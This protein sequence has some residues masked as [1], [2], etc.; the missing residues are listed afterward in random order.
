MARKALIGIVALL[1]V[2]FFTSVICPPVHERDG[3]PDETVGVADTLPNAGEA[4]A[5]DRSPSE[6][7]PPTRDTIP[8]APS[9]AAVRFAIELVD[10]QGTPLNGATATLAQLEFEELTGDRQSAL[11][12]SQAT[13][14][15]GE[16]FLRAPYPGS[17]LIRAHMDSNLSAEM[18]MDL[19]LPEG[20]ERP[21][22]ML[23]RAAF[24]AGTVQNLSGD[25]VVYGELVLTNVDTGTEQIA[26]A[27]GTHAE[28]KTA[29]LASGSWTIAWREHR[30]AE[31]DPRLL[32]RTPLAPGETRNLQFTLP[33]G[34]A[35]SG[36]VPGVL[37]S[38]R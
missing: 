28:F 34:E 6:G 21:Q 10:D 4:Q 27:R 26:R 22:L 5:G 14:N 25:S 38:P 7:T 35:T 3:L 2:I 31:V 1:A 33:R 17:Y 13:S 9:M 37:P 32:Y 16:A 18:R 29:A 36:A 24:L 23:P 15:E 12:V 19:P 11:D 20:A 8:P 30:H